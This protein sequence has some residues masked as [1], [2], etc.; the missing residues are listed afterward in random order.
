MSITS[1]HSQ[2]PMAKKSRAY[3]TL[4]DELRRAVRAS[5]FADGV[6]LP[7][8]A[9]LS[10]RHGV[11]RQT[12]RRAM[13]ELVNEGLIYRV[14]GR[15]TFAV[16]SSERFIRQLGS[17]EDLMALR[18]DT[19]SELVVPLHHRVDIENAG[20][21]RLATDDIMS[22][23]LVRYH[24]GQPIAVTTAYM[25]T[26]IGSRVVG[27]PELTE[28][29]RRRNFTVFGT[30]EQVTGITIREAEQSITAVSAPPGPASYLHA[31]PDAPLLR[32]DRVYLDQDGNPIEL[33][34]SYFNPQFYSYRIRL[35]RQ[36][37]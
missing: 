2:D 3:A 6:R 16:E 12:V 37:G 27:V 23:T 30:I 28:V 10:E 32:V 24:S 22:L 33:A 1:T 8:E 36:L 17:I 26:E 31:A 20:R 14:A 13:Q 11:S 19:E 21:L 34:I 5:E 25:S 4:A 29:G 9:E 7:T 15:G 18:L 35:Q